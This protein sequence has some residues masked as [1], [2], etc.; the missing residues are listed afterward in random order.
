MSIMFWFAP[1]SEICKVLLQQSL[2]KGNISPRFI[3]LL[4]F[5]LVLEK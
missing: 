2:A 5:N 1:K 4:K 3:L